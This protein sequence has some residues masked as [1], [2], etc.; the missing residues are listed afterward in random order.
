MVETP[1]RLQAYK[2]VF[3]GLHDSNVIA[4]CATRPSRD[5]EIKTRIQRPVLINNQAAFQGKV[6]GNSPRPARLVREILCIP[7]HEKLSDDDQTFVINAVEAFF[8][9]RL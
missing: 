4:R 3:I 2:G 5:L 7:A 6:R 9:G 1:P 8:R